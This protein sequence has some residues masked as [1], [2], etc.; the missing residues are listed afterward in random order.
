MDYKSVSFCKDTQRAKDAELIV[1]FAEWYCAAHH[2][3]AKRKPLASQ[4]VDAEIYD[5]RVPFLCD[6]CAEYARYAEQRTKLCPHEPK[7]F[8][9]NCDIKCYKPDMAEYSRIVMRYSGSRS[10]FSRYCLRAIQHVFA[11]LR[12]HKQTGGTKKI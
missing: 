9:T 10:I 7:P 6:K 2:R 5:R 12:H 8:C 1:R 11:A 4:G 3:S